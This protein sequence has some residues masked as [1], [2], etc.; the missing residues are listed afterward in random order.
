LNLENR[1]FDTADLGPEGVVLYE[2]L[3]KLPIPAEVA[4][5]RELQHAVGRIVLQ[6]SVEHVIVETLRSANETLRFRRAAFFSAER[7]GSYTDCV[8]NDGGITTE[9]VRFSPASNASFLAARSG[10]PIEGFATDLWVPLVDA[11]NRYLMCAVRHD[12]QPFGFLYVDDPRCE[13]R[14]T[15]EVEAIATLSMIAG[16]A[17][18]NALLFE[19]S[20][21][22]A[23]RDPLTGLLNRRAFAERLQ[24]ELETCR[25]HAFSLLYIALDVDDFKLVNDR[26]GHA[27]GDALLRRLGNALMTM[28]RAEDAVA[29]LGGDE[30]AVVMAKVDP[31]LSA[32]SLE[33]IN[34]LLRHAGV[35]CSLGAAL[36]PRDGFDAATL[37]RAADRALYS[38]KAGG[39]DRF[40]FA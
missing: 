33:R 1:L 6:R 5:R 4:V 32:S 2:P 36:Y 34:E 10:F 19:R 12:A 23:S 15:L 22:L 40:A 30:F 24:Q 3:N 18:R 14:E 17:S 38:A 7:D 25:R 20:E 29:R 31:S 26:S 37:A 16:V 9:P 11:R 21:A 35:R 28:S 39:K 8:L 27:E 13:T